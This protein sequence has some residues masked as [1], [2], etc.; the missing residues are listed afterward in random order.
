MSVTE[1]GG[2][3]A[4]AGL[5]CPYRN[6]L[7]STGNNPPETNLFLLQM[8]RDDEHAPAIR[9]NTAP[10][11]SAARIQKVNR[12]T[13]GLAGSSEEWSYFLTRWNDYVEAT[14]VA[15]KERI[16]QLLECCEEDLRKD[17]TRCAGGSLTN[18]TETEVLEAIQQLA[19]RQENTMVARVALYEMR[20]DHEE[21]V[22]SYGARIR[23]QANICKYMIKCPGC[24]EDVNY[25]EPMLRDVLTRGIADNEIQLDLLG[26]AN[27]DMSLEQT[28]KYIEAKESGKRSVSK[29]LH[30]QSVNSARSQ[31]KQTKQNELQQRN[32]QRSES[33]PPNELCDYCGKPGH[34]KKAP[35]NTRKKKCLAFGQTC[36]YCSRPNHY[37]IMCHKKPQQQQQEGARA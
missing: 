32:G 19:V 3:A 21:P 11:A 28:F 7:F 29:L 26:D 25:T 9:A 5:T 33:K 14:H 6:C 16:I 1:D 18:K 12:P 27:Q 34:G 35:P 23:G 31:Y 30:I 36:S 10:T 17:L 4:A 13:L 20:Q 2:T 15:G 8:H 24:N 37:E 22:R